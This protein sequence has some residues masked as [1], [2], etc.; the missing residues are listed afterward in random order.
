[1]VFGRTVP[2]GMKLDIYLGDTVMVD[3]PNY[4][5]PYWDD[6]NRRLVPEKGSKQIKQLQ[7]Y[8][9]FKLVSNGDGTFE[10]IEDGLSKSKNPYI[11]EHVLMAG[12]IITIGKV[13]LTNG[14]ADKTMIQKL[15]KDMP[16]S[17]NDSDPNRPQVD[18]HYLVK[19]IEIDGHFARDDLDSRKLV[20]QS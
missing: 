8:R 16:F 7:C 10:V 3:N 18:T 6:W 5:A 11:Q 14:G 13:T 17:Y 2:E 19:D 12:T 1:M 9:K 20:D 15:Q 4:E